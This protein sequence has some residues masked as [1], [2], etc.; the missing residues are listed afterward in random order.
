MKRALAAALVLLVLWLVLARERKMPPTIQ[1]AKAKHADRILAMQG[2]VSMGIGRD[3]DGHE[4]IVIGL[5]RPRPDTQ[6]R[7]PTQLEGHPVR[8]EIIGAVRAQ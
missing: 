3:A 4:V 7:L 8:V 5:D 6:A 1:E 2:V